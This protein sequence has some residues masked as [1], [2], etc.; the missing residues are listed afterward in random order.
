MTPLTQFPRPL[1]MNHFCIVVRVNE[2]NVYNKLTI[3]VF[4]QN[5]VQKQKLVIQK[6][7]IHSHL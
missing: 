2:N 4:N 3:I 7:T 5:Y 6:D 1:P